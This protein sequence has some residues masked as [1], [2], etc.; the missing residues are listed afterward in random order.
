VILFHPIFAPGR[1]VSVGWSKLCQNTFDEF[2]E[3]LNIRFPVLERIARVLS[4]V[5]FAWVDQIMDSVD[6]F[7]TTRLPLWEIVSSNELVLLKGLS[8]FAT[9][10]EVN[11]G[12]VL[13]QIPK[14]QLNVFWVDLVL[15]L[16]NPSA[17]LPFLEMSLSLAASAWPGMMV[18]IPTH[19]GG[20]LR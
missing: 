15:V 16:K 19:L 12:T 18:S 5:A 9:H 3:S 13:N 1:S 11:C 7:K 2:E 8:L 17:Y 20:I 10:A 4:L 14:Y 6:W